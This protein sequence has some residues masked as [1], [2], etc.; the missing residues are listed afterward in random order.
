MLSSL[1]AKP[2]LLNLKAIL[3]FWANALSEIFYAIQSI[4]PVFLVLGESIGASK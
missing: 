3:R 2:V 4:K 1:V